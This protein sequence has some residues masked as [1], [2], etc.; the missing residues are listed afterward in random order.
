MK[1]ML[2][3]RV[4]FS[5]AV[6]L[7]SLMFIFNI[8]LILIYFL[9]SLDFEFFRKFGVQMADSSHTHPLLLLLQRQKVRKVEVKYREM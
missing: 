7:L 1:H 4:E 5:A 3:L 2:R 9:P 6:A 8:I